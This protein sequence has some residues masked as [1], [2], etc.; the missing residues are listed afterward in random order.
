M[1][2]PVI[3]GAGIAGLSAANNFIDHGIQ[4]II[5][6]A[7]LIGR[8]KVCGEFFSP[9][10]LFFLEK[11]EIP[12]VTIKKGNF[13]T[14]NYNYSFNFPKV[15][16]SISRSECELL[17]AKRIIN[18]NGIIYTNTSVTEIIN[19]KNNNENH[20]IKLSNGK[21]LETNK[22]VIATGRLFNTNS[23]QEP[24]YIGIKAHF[25]NFNIPNELFMYMLPSAYLGVTYV[26]NSTVN[27]CCLAKKQLVDKYEN[28]SD[29]MQ[30]FFKHFPDLNKKF[31]SS[32]CLFNDWLKAYVFDFGIKK[33]PDWP[34][35]YF[36]GDA[37]ALIYPASGN[38]L[39]MGL[40]SGIM[41]SDYI[42]SNTKINFKKNWYKR[43]SKRIYY[44]KF[45]HN[46][47][48]TSKISNIGFR[49]ANLYPEI[50]KKFFKITRDRFNDF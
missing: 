35:C 38:G 15:A 50:S 48:M 33:T 31:N 19:A 26:N 20:L 12:F 3:I 49:I 8:D 4:P 27:V 41:A 1:N 24:K 47:F 2:P 11:W 43:Y 7:D 25:K 21:V 29:F 37:A 34:N 17:L 40:T 39:A 14:K 22:L 46:F 18:K 44:A 10:A 5:I 13:I 45:L 30:F 23:M 6:E 28:I 9:E 42:I 32:I 36:I 16:G